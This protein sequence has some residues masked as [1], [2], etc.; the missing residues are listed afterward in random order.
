MYII[1]IRYLYLYIYVFIY[2]HVYYILGADIHIYIR[3]IRYIYLYIS[4][5]MY[6]YNCIYIYMPCPSHF[7][8]ALMQLC[9]RCVSAADSLGAGAARLPC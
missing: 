1:Y 4:I 2:I 3:Y 6:I 8:G 9:V 5:Y 7:H